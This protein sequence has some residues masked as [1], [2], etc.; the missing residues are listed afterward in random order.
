MN[1][2]ITSV[3]FGLVT[4]NTMV[5]ADPSRPRL[6]VGIVVD[7]LRTD[8]MEYLR[9]LFGEKGFKRL[10]EQGMYMPDVDFNVDLSDAATATAMLYTGAYPNATGVP[11]HKVYDAATKSVVPPLSDPATIGNFTNDT[12]SPASLR[13]STISDEI[14]IDGT[15]V[16]YVYSI[17]PDPQQALI[18]AGHAGNSAVWLDVHTGNWATTTYYK[19][20]P[21]A[22]TRRNY[23]S[24]LSLR[25]DTMQWKPVLPLDRYPGLPAQKR[26]YPFRYTFPKSDRDVYRNF[27]NTPLINR[28][29]TDLAIDYLS[30]LNMGR[31]GD[32]IDMLNI[33]YTARPYKGVRDGDFRIELE[34]TYVRLDAQL[35]RLFDAIDRYVGLNNTLVYL[36]GTGYYDD[37]APNDERYRLPSGTFSVKRATSLLNSYLAARYGNGDYVDTYWDGRIYLDH[38]EMERKGLDS[39]EVTQSARDFLVRMSG[40]ADARSIADILNGQTEEAERQRRLIDPRNGGDIVLEFSPGWTISDDL[41]FPVESKDIRHSAITTPAFLMG[42]GIEPRVIGAPVDATALAPTVTGRLRI[43]S[44]NGAVSKA[45]R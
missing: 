19:D 35:E 30:Q 7:Q 11:G 21:A 20:A 41:R 1:R 4:I 22:M 31:R 13:L 8:Y 10:M 34:D 2:L 12:Y 5:L 40:V 25:L 16:A 15:G 33:A 39:R 26:M 28:E 27:A 17:A 18:M 36:S 3:L 29:V 45:V 37:A 23:D 44:P 6:V 14:A 24:P 42:A 9:S 43:R 38:A 32:A